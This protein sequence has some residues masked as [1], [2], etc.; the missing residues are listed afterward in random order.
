MA[1]ALHIM[2]ELKPSG[3]ERMF[4]SSFPHW[5]QAGWE[6][7]IVGSGKVHPFAE[8][9]QKIGY[10]IIMIPSLK[11]AKGLLSLIRIFR[12]NQW[13]IIHNHSESM[14]GPISLL[15]R[16]VSPKTPIVRT[17][18]NCFQF[19]G[20]ERFKRN[21]QNFMEA[22]SKVCH[23]S[24]SLDVQQNELKLWDVSSQIIENWVDIEGI[25]KA[26]KKPK[27]MEKS[28]NLLVALVGNCSPIKNHEFALNVLSQFEVIQ[29][30]HIGEQ[31]RITH[32]ERNLLNSL[33]SKGALLHDG[34]SDNVFD[35]F[36]LVDVHILS[37]VHEGM[38]LVIA[39]SMTL[40]IETW[41][42]DVPGVQWAKEL[43][44]VRFFESQ[45]QLRQLIEEKLQSDL[46]NP[47]LAEVNSDVLNRFSPN[48]G[49]VE[50]TSLYNSLISI[51]N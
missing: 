34:P 41:I 50:Y 28:G 18:H 32:D 17:I 51:A 33:K 12:L 10:D 39:E 49:V 7:V 22:K 20:R 43:P 13:D 29:I 14:H 16:I 35:F 37:S 44:G 8:T 4:E 36:C 40:G 31:S 38:G 11:S 48:R 46:Y 26:K 42:R 21:L 2:N 1:T 6:I 30:F 9:L 27:K 3:M 23:V 15:S 19:S 25:Y 24:P 5:K 45:Q 47:I